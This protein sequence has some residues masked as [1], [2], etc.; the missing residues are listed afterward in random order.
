MPLLPSRTGHEGALRDPCGELLRLLE[1]AEGD[2]NPAGRPDACGVMVGGGVAL[3][4]EE[5]HVAVPELTTQW[6]TV[7]V[8]YCNTV[9]ATKGCKRGV[10]GIASM[11]GA[12]GL[13]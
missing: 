8:Q 3:R 10:V 1:G 4:L 11:A 12:C 5:V 6:L 9:L 2:W 13:A 7:R